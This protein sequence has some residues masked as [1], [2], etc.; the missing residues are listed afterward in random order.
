VTIDARRTSDAADTAFTLTA[1]I[2]GAVVAPNPDTIA[3]A[4]IGVPIGRSYTITNLYGAFTGNAVGS[5]LGSAFR[6]TPTIANLG[7]NVITFTVAP[8]STNLRVAIGSTSDPAADLDLYV[9]YCNPSCNQ[10][11]QAADGDSEEAVSFNSPAAGNWAALV[12]GYSV[13]AG[14]TS[15]TYVDVFVNSAFGSVAVTDAS[16]LRPAGSSW[17]VPAAVTVN[18]APAPGR[19]LQGTVNV[20]AGAVLVGSGEVVVTSIAP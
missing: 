17:N 4:T 13:P 19:V 15:Y 9:F 12:D 3:S 14:T 1:S 10:V 11:G 20:V 16:A 7:Q 6:A 18:A 2:L 5:T 8:G